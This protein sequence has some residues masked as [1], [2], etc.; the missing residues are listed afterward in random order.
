M[1][2]ILAGFMAHQPKTKLGC[3]SGGV[4]EPLLGRSGP[5]MTIVDLQAAVQSARNKQVAMQNVIL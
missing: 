2:V 5:R 4:S 1:R 3:D